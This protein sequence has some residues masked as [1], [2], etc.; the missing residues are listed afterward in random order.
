MNIKLLISKEGK[1]LLT[2]ESFFS[3]R[4]ERVIFDFLN[5]KL[6]FLFEGET[7]PFLL[8]CDVDDHIAGYMVHRKNCGVGFV[9]DGVLRQAVFLPL[10]VENRWQK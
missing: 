6:A 3:K 7:N 2:C 4:I 9:Q 5:R 8:N 1:V 10:Q